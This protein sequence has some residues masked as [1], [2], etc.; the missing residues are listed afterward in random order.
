M[1]ME[2]LAG[3]VAEDGSAARRN[4]A[5]GDLKDEAGEELLDVLAVGEVGGFR[6]EV[7]GEVFGVAWSRWKDGGELLAEMAEAETG[8]KVRAAKPALR[9]IGI[10]MLATRG[11]CRGVGCAGGRG[12]GIAGFQVQDFDVRAR[13]GHDLSSFWR[14]G[15]T[16]PPPLL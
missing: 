9:A 11:A 10:A 14:Q 6:E 5:P 1:G 2:E 3:E 13:C 12:F 7:G 4:A 16:H 15:G 8:P